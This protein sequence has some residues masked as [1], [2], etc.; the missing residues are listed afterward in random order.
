MKISFNPRINYNNFNYY[1]VNKTKNLP[2]DSFELSFKGS[3]TKK[4]GK[5]PFDGSDDYSLYKLTQKTL[6]NYRFSKIPAETKRAAHDSMQAAR[7]VKGKLDKKYG[8]DNYVF[9]SIGTS[10]AGVAKTIEYMGGDVRYVPI[11]SLRDVQFS[12][13]E[14]PEYQDYE[15]YSKFLD[16]IGL[17]RNDVIKSGKKHVFCD[18]TCSG[19]TLNAVQYYAQRRGIPDEYTDFR[20][21]N[22]M[23]ADYALSNPEKTGDILRYNKY[24]LEDSNIGKYTGI[25]HLHCMLVNN[26][27]EALKTPQG[28]A[29]K[30]FDFALLYY[31]DK[32]GLL[33]K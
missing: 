10:P 13:R 7:I 11:S 18:Y 5:V 32:K 12:Y 21:L 15:N 22:G 25:P 16:S 29:S 20:S 1:R 23:L 24:Y 19:I 28:K 31:L 9:V 17:D 33:K 6:K 27:D 2:Y 30:D 8:K 14:L 4:N 26:I 3:K